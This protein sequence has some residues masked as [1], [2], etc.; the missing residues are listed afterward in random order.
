MGVSEVTVGRLH[1]QPHP[2]EVDGPN[3]KQPGS[4]T[5]SLTGGWA[6]LHPTLGFYW[7]NKEKN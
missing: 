1:P 5:V 6:R 7:S 4:Y 2:C 3:H